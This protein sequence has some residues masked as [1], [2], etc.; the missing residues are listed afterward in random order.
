MSVLAITLFASL[1]LVGCGSGSDS[2]SSESASSQS[3]DIA[4]V[5][6]K[7]SELVQAEPS[8]PDLASLA[9][10]IFDIAGI[11]DAMSGDDQNSTIG[12]SIS[13]LTLAY[14]AAVM[15]EQTTGR[16]QFHDL[17]A[18]TERTCGN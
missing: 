16:G 14:E 18:A 5:C 12:S 4:D 1:S 11:Y 10:Q 7:V 17:L 2:T 9:I 8:A 13:T 15:E 3:S 6:A